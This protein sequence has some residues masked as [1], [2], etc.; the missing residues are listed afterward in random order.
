M[1]KAVVESGTGAAAIPELMVKK[2]LQLSTLRS[3]KI[4]DTQPS[5]NV[6]FDIIKPVLKLKHRQRFQTAITKAFE[7]ILT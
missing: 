5:S 2:E 1:V 3:I 6:C 7:Q 4:I